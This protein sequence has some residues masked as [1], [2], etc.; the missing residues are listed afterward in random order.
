MSRL[1]CAMC[2][3]PMAPFCLLGGMAIGPKCA[4]RAGLTPAKARKNR[5]VVFVKRAPPVKGPQNLELF[6]GLTP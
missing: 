1:V 3:R 5:D 4:Q 6:E 2:G